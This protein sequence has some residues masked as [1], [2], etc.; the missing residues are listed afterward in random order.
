VYASTLT[1]NNPFQPSRQQH[2]EVKGRHERSP[3]TRWYTYLAVYLP[4]PELAIHW[5]DDSVTLIPKIDDFF[6]QIM[7]CSMF[8]NPI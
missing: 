8:E 1:G 2:L 4:S 7:F 6:N 3:L 5:S